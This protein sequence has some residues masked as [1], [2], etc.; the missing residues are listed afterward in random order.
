MSRG[1]GLEAGKGRKLGLVYP[2]DTWVASTVLFLP[3]KHI[4]P[5][6]KPVITR[7]PSLPPETTGVSTLTPSNLFREQ[8]RDL[9]N[10]QIHRPPLKN[11]L[12]KPREE[13]LLVQRG[14]RTLP[15]LS[16]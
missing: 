4:P 1:L 2:P 5:F 9:T 3:S 7:V 12:H 16:G 6:V 15:R 13:D 14:K 11:G 10:N 8:G